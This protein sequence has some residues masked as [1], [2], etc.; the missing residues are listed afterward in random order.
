MAN[1]KIC[2]RKTILSWKLNKAKKEFWRVFSIYVRMRDKGVCFSCR[3][4]ILNF[5]NKKGEVQPGYKAG[6]GG[7]FVTAKSCGLALYFHERNVHCQCYQCNINLSGNWLEYRKK[8][9]EVYGLKATEE[10]EQ[11]KWTGNVKYS[12]VDYADKIEEYAEKVRKLEENY[13]KE[14]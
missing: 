14:E 4:K 1:L 13:K 10:I 11:L 6:Q 5:Y 2:K 12:V 8:M 7:H 3:K 9:I